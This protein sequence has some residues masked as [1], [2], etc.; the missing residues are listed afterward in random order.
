MTFESAIYDAGIRQLKDIKDDLKLGRR[1]VQFQRRQIQI[2]HVTLFHREDS[3]L[4]RGE[5]NPGLEQDVL[6]R[7]IQDF[8][9]L[10]FV[11]RQPFNT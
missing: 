7:L 2:H 9:A 4:S 8:P 5:I 1:R 6:N 11:G 10:E 3:Q